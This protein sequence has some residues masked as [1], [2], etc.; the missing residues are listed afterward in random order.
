M[1]LDI[2]TNWL[3]QPGDA[4][5]H[6][7]EP[8]EDEISLAEIAVV[9]GD[10][11]LTRAEDLETNAVRDHAVLPAHR[12]A[13]WLVWNWWRLRWEPRRQGTKPLLGWARAHRM[14][15]IGRG[16]L[17]PDITFGSDGAR[18]L[19]MAKPSPPV[20]AEPLRYLAD[21]V[22]VIPASMF[23]TGVD[24][25]LARVLK[26]LA[27]HPT[28]LKT[29]WME[30]AVE[31]ADPELATYRRLEA[32]LGCDPD[33]AD[34]A[35]IERLLRD[36]EDLGQEA[37]AELAAAGDGQPA[38][39]E[40]L[41][42]WARQTG[43]DV[44]PGDGLR[45]EGG[46][47]EPARASVPAWRVGVETARR[48]RQQAG[49]GE[50]PV[51]NERLTNLCAV[52]RAVLTGSG[53]MRIA[54]ELAE[55]EGRARVVLRSKWETGR[56]FELARLLGDRLLGAASERLH[57]ATT[58]ST[59]RQKMQ[60]AFAAELLCPIE[61]LRD[62]LKEDFSDEAQDDAAQIF[63]VSPRTV[64]TLLANNGYI[65]REELYDPDTRAA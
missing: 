12:L 44:R 15:T 55:P 18:M 46:T 53:L 2:T 65:D 59:Y 26:H 3:R 35:V 4:I 25:F 64:A 37:M 29:Q 57:P 62:V 32:L 50:G 38:T 33:Q 17:W 1:T 24:E 13:E 39:A 34:P 58:S 6:S 40:D 10:R 7:L 60:R 28:E 42:S 27:K 49:L 19:V 23:E 45:L 5:T 31:R 8:I 41:H 14:A 11:C 51:S 47:A 30:L 20:A 43:F 56:R 61:A 21:Q 16:W 63:N 22:V 52:D 9:V 36:A 54:F 48:V